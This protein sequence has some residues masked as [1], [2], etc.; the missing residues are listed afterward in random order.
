MGNRSSWNTVGHP[1]ILEKNASH[2]GINIIG[3][4]SILNNFHTVNNIYSSK[5]SITSKEIRAHIEYL[6][7]L[8]PDKKVVIFMDNAKIHTSVEILSI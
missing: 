3:S 7:E 5:Q 6:I 4:T 2:E 8:N 1:P